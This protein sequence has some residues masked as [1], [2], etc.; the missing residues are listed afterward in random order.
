MNRNYSWLITPQAGTQI[1]WIDVG[2]DTTTPFISGI[3]AP[4][5][6]SYTY[7][8]NDSTNHQTSPS[9]HGTIVAINGACSTVMRWSGP[10][11]NST[12]EIAFNGPRYLHTSEWD[13]SNF[14]VANW[15]RPLGMGA[16]PIHA[17]KYGFVP[18]AGDEQDDAR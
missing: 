5:N 16:G 11:M 12:F 3:V 8:T 2:V 15:S 10:P 18:V 6:W 17:P 4:P 1:A 9:T 13:T 7:N 14:A